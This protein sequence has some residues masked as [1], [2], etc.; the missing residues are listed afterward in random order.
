[1][2]GRT[3]KLHTGRCGRSAQP[4]WAKRMAW[5]APGGQGSSEAL[6]NVHACGYTWRACAVTIAVAKRLATTVRAERIVV[7]KPLLHGGALQ[8]GVGTGKAS[9]GAWAASSVAPSM[10]WTRPRNAARRYR[11]S[12]ERRA[13][14][15]TAGGGERRRQPTVSSVTLPYLLTYLQRSCEVANPCIGICHARDACSLW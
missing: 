4:H 3:C 8:T 2:D 14:D 1:M 6:W 13:Q 12:H 10:A 11:S 9:A 5:S 7:G 15:K